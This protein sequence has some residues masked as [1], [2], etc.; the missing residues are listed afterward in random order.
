LNRPS[1]LVSSLGTVFLAFEPWS[2]PSFALRIAPPGWVP[3]NPVLDAFPERLLQAPSGARRFRSAG[4]FRFRLQA[5]ALTPVLACRVSRRRPRR[6]GRE[7]LSAFP[8]DGSGSFQRRAPR[9]P[10][11]CSPDSNRRRRTTAAPPDGRR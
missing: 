9:G 7:F 2:D 10:N 1:N 8:C 5:P 3:R 6:S 11:V 4:G